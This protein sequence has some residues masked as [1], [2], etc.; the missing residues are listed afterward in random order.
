MKFFATITTLALTGAAYAMPFAEAMAQL[1][2]TTIECHIACGNAILESRKCEQITN[3][4]AEYEACLCTA[5]S[6]FMERIDDCLYCGWPL[7]SAY[8]PYLTEPLLTCDLPIEPTGPLSF[9][10]P[11][12]SVTTYTYTPLATSP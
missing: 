3:T 9:S 6:G 7:W 2:G 5:G 11:P 1:P 12:P 8:S 10:V 4:D